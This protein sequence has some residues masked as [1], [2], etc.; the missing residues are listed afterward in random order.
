MYNGVEYTQSIT[1]VDSQWKD[2]DTQLLTTIAVT[3]VEPAY[4]QESI[5][6]CHS[7]EWNDEV[8][9]TSGEYTFTS[10]T[11]H[12]CDSVITLSLT[13]LP[14]PEIEHDTILLCASELPYNWFGQALDQTGDFVY[15]KT[16]PEGCDSI[17]YN[18][19]LTTFNQ[20]LPEEISR[21]VVEVDDQGIV[22]DTLVST[23]EIMNFIDADPWYAPYALVTWWI[24]DNQNWNPLNDSPLDSNTLEVKLKYTVQ[25]D[26]GIVESEVYEYNF[27][28]TGVE[29]GAI[30]TSGV[31]KI[32][33]NNQL[34]LLRD[35]RIYTT[36]GT[37]V[38]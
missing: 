10:T 8:Y 25:T 14:E 26:C 22:I 2:A 32:F 12:G 36:L 4:T 1:L 21:P 16:Y 27:T 38:K 28:T 13:I 34:Y 20:A 3:F 5:R 19:Y 17:V 35:G 24:Y 6:A 7:Y 23:E 30:G 15:S 31:R 29:E 33:L 9:T 37:Q 11:S 18:L